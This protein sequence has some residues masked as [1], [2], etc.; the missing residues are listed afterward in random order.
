MGVCCIFFLHFANITYSFFFF[1]FSFAK[2][3]R[4]L[5][6]DGSGEI[7]PQELHDALNELGRRTSMAEAE[8][9]IAQYDDDNSNSI[10]LEE[11]IDLMSTSGSEEVRFRQSRI[12]FFF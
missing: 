7:D 1:F 8:E 11:F 12:G 9:M 6:Q 5:L 10:G 3:R 4:L 2:T